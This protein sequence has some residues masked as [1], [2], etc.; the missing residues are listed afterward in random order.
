MG[1]RTRVGI[2]SE[3]PSHWED[4][5]GLIHLPK[6]YCRNSVTGG[7]LSWGPSGFPSAAGTKAGVLGCRCNIPSWTRYRGGAKSAMAQLIALQ[8]EQGDPCNLIPN[9]LS[10]DYF[11]VYFLQTAFSPCLS[12]PPPHFILLLLSRVPVSSYFCSPFQRKS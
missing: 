1:H 12:F 8:T 6:L 11:L 7:Q 10:P 3:T 5:G 9:V 4:V 2:W